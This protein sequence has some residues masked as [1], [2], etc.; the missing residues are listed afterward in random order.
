MINDRYAIPNSTISS[1]YDFK[2][3]RP[4]ISEKHSQMS[5]ISWKEHFKECLLEG[6]YMVNNYCKFNKLVGFLDNMTFENFSLFMYNNSSKEKQKY[7]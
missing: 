5:Y 7:V 3:I 4:Y 2:I 1:N 6:Y